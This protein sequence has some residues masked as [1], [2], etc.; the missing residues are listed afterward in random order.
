MGMTKAK[1]KTYTDKYARLKGDTKKL[2][3]QLAQ[4]DRLTEPEQLEVFKA[5]QDLPAPAP[6]HP[7]QDIRDQETAEKNTRLDPKR[8]NSSLNL[9]EYDY[10]A[11]DG[12]VGEDFKKYVEMVEG[13]VDNRIPGRPV[14]KKRGM[15][16][17][18]PRK[19][20]V[21]EV[22]DVR[23][24]FVEMYPGMQNSPTRLDGIMV[25]L[26]KPIHTTQ[27]RV[28]QAVLLNQQVQNAQARGGAD[29]GVRVGLA[30]YYLLK[31]D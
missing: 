2:Q 5:I 11:T 13:I 16:Q 25:N 23:P 1:L 4:D 15:L 3:D 20:Y 24:V 9:S 19:A 26:P 28:E 31:K 29:Q 21:F 18:E 27:I 8:A 30:R 12:F 6:P 17:N 22:Y 7:D 14:V 10:L